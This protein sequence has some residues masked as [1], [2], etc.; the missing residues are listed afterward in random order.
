MKQILAVVFSS[1]GEIA[2][3]MESDPIV[4]SAMPR[5]MASVDVSVLEQDA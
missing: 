3:W 1:I 4:L 5:E 2:A